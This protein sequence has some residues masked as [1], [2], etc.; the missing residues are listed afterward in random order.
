MKIKVVL[1]DFYILYFKANLALELYGDIP[2]TPSSRVR[3]VYKYLAY[4]S[5]FL[6]FNFDLNY[7]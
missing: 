4:G 3:R 7:R 5:P 1:G 6:T 2:E